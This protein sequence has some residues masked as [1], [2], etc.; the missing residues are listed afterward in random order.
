MP[1]Q[2][3]SLADSKGS[4]PLRSALAL[5]CAASHGVAAQRVEDAIAFALTESSKA[6]R[7]DASQRRA[8]LMESNSASVMCGG[9]SRGFLGNLSSM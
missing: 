2:F 8:C 4:A 9:A 3:G 5:R 6:Q 7:W 1:W